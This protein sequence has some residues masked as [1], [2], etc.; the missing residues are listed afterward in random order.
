MS[1]NVD[2]IIN[3]NSLVLMVSEEEAKYLCQNPEY[4][5]LKD[6]VITELRSRANLGHSIV[7]SVEIL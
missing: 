6:K 1:K 4:G 2:V 3:L 5:L 7:E